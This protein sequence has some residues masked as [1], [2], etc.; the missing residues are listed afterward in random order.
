MAKKRRAPKPPTS[1]ELLGHRVQRIINSSKAQS[2]K[3]A[4]I[5]HQPDESIED[6]DRLIEELETL[7]AVTM[8]RHEDG[9]VGLRWNPA[10]PMA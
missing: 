10:E 3:H 6:W 5:E 7:E 8:I 9:S 1:Y 2:A 4:V